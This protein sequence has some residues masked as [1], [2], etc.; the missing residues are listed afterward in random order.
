MRSFR[1]L[2]HPGERA[3]N[4]ISKRGSSPVPAI[5]AGSRGDGGIAPP[6]GSRRHSGAGTIGRVRAGPA[7]ESAT[8]ESATTIVGV[9]H[10]RIAAPLMQIDFE[11]ARAARRSQV[12]RIEGRRLQPER[13]RTRPP[14]RRRDSA[15]QRPGELQ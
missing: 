5:E 8:T 12:E 1:F 2:F 7:T 14:C 10:G 9:N 3:P 6:N 4:G 11:L 15:R 13:F